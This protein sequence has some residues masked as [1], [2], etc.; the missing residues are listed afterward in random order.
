MAVDIVARSTAI[1]AA[2]S[3]TTVVANP[4]LAGT[5]PDLTGLQVGTDAYAIKTYKKF[6]NS[7][8][9][10][11]TT[12]QFL[13][14][15][16]ADTDAVEGMVYLG[17]IACSDLPASMNNV[18]AIVEIIRSAVG[19]SKVIHT[20]I[21][22]GNTAPYRW[23]RTYWNNGTNDSGWIAFSQVA[24]NPTLAGTESSLTGLEVNG[25]KYKVD[26][27]TT[28]V[29]N[30]TLVGTESDLTGLQVG[31]TKYKVPSGGGE[32]TPDYGKTIL[33]EDTIEIDED[34]P[35]GPELIADNFES[36]LN[37]LFGQANLSWW[38]DFMESA[39]N[40]G[41]SDIYGFIPSDYR[42][43]LTYSDGTT[44][45]TS[46]STAK[47][48]GK[49][50]GTSDFVSNSS[51]EYGYG[52]IY[53]EPQSEKEGT[54]YFYFT[55]PTATIDDTISF[56]IKIDDSGDP[57]EFVFPDGYIHCDFAD[58]ELA[59][60]L[61][62]WR[63]SCNTHLASPN[64]STPYV[65]S[66]LDFIGKHIN[67]DKLIALLEDVDSNILSVDVNDTDRC[68]CIQL[69]NTAS[70]Y[71]FFYASNDFN[72]ICTTRDGS[73]LFYSILGSSTE[74][75]ADYWE[76]VS[77][78]PEIGDPLTLRDFLD[79][80]KSDIEA[81]TFD[82]I[83]IQ[84]ASGSMNQQTLDGSIVLSTYKTFPDYLNNAPIRITY[85][86]LMSIFDDVV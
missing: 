56:N 47:D 18:E 51:W 75:Y 34:A 67:V 14:A 29:A 2:E 54:V 3:A 30:P 5:E 61:I 81:I 36:F 62:I 63:P 35:D 39:Y 68:F 40:S 84:V 15:I 8:N 17:D 10:T 77:N 33:C 71:G 24:A 76:E 16:N 60:K 74:H 38:T 69:F 50:P 66:A 80:N 85:G 7:W 19:G 65:A 59:S 11:G 46:G 45:T 6:D 32:S 1:K 42:F 37:D 41:E 49:Y 28:V 44:A 52:Y 25:T 78:P 27:G 57:A 73:G 79:D 72:I 31:N 58:N 82:A 70:M 48:I 43:T 13:D 83:N 12:K 64:I 55:E 4:T 20:T 53:Y 26:T 23:E 21:T 9:T 86:Q 22:S